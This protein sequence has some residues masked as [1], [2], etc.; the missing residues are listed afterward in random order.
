MDFK[1]SQANKKHFF[2]LG[3][4]WFLY[5]LFVISLGSCSLEMKMTK[6]GKYDIFYTLSEVDETG[7]NYDYEV[8]FMQ[9]LEENKAKKIIN[10]CIDENE[11]AMKKYGTIYNLK[12]GYFTI[13]IL[14]FLF[15]LCLPYYFMYKFNVFK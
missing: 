1:I 11:K 5:S 4:A 6:D 12:T 14:I 8:I 7:S 2:Y 10:D 3:I 13:D 9:S 15:I